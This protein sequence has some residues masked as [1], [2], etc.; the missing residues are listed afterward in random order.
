MQVGLARRNEIDGLAGFCPGEHKTMRKQ[1]SSEEGQIDDHEQQTEPMSRVFLSPN[2]SDIHKGVP[3]PQLDE[4]PF[5]RQSAGPIGSFNRAPGIPP[6]YP[7]LPSAPVEGHNGRPAGGV[8]PRIHTRKAAPR[9]PHRSSFPAFVGLFFVAVEL[10]LLLRLICLLFGFS[11]NDLWVGLVYTLSA[12][13]VLPFRLLLENI[14]IPILYGT[15]LYSDLI[16]I[17]ALLMYGLLSRIL[18]RFLKALLHSR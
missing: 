1:E 2:A 10:L 9:Q 17:F 18:V 15:E 13:F 16:I 7:V 14:K 4:R 11:S 6:A 12:I 5:P 8:P 3:A